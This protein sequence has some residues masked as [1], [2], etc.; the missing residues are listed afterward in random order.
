MKKRREALFERITQRPEGG[1]DNL[2]IANNGGRVGKATMDPPALAQPERA[3]FGSGIADRNHQV[4]ISTLEF[5]GML[6]ATGMLDA[7]LCEHLQRQGVDNSGWPG[8]GTESLPV[9]T[10]AGVDDGLRHLRA[11]GVPRA[12]EKDFALLTGHVYRISSSRKLIPVK[13]Q[14]SQAAVSVSV[15]KVVISAGEGM[16]PNDT[17][18]S[19][20]TSPGV[21]MML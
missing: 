15:R 14:A 6:G 10:Q 18:F 9:C 20:I 12:E 4:K 21:D 19:L 7:D 16:R 3:V 5:I 13:H 8:A 17:S 1:E 11:A 2:L